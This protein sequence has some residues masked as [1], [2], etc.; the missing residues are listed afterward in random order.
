[1]SKIIHFIK[2]IAFAIAWLVQPGNLHGQCT[3]S[4]FPD[5]VTF[6][7]FSETKTVDLQLDYNCPIYI[8]SPPVLDATII[9]NT[10][11]ISI[12][13]HITMVELADY[14]NGAEIMLQDA[15][16]YELLGAVY[17]YFGMLPPPLIPGQ[18]AC[19]LTSIIAGTSPGTIFN[20]ESP[21]GGDGDYSFQWQL[22][23]DGGYQWTNILNAGS[24]F[25][26]CHVLNVTTIFRRIV[27]SGIQTDYSNHLVISVSQAP[28]AAGQIAGTV[29]S[30]EYGKSPGIFTNAVYPTGGTGTY[31]YQWQQS[32]DNG[33]SWNN[34]S[35]ANNFEYSCYAL[36]KPTLFRRSVFSGIQAAQSNQ[37][38]ISVTA[39]AAPVLSPLGENY[40][41]TKTMLDNTG[42]ASSDRTDYSDGLGR[43]A[44]TVLHKSS[45]GQKDIV[46]L[47]E[48]DE[49]GR[50][51]NS[52][53]PVPVTTA[54]GEFVTHSTVKT[55]SN[56]FYGDAYAYDKAVYEP[57]PLNR[58]TD[59]YGP[60]AAW[61]T[62]QKRISTSRY[63]NSST[64]ELSCILYA[65]ASGTSLQNKG[66]CGPGEL[67]VTKTTDEDGHI[68]YT[69][70]DKLGQVVLERVMNGSAMNDTYSVYDD[71]GN[72]R[73]VLPPAAAD[74]LNTVSTWTDENQTLKDYAYIYKYDGQSR[75][76]LKKLPGND[77]IE[78]RYDRADRPVFSQDGNRRAKGEWSFFF[79]DVFGRQTV[80][81]IWKSASLPALDNLVVKTGYTG[82]GTLAGHTVNLTLPQVEL[83][84]VNYYD[85]HAFTSGV[86]QLD[87]VTPP[88]GYGTQFSSAK[89]LLTGTRTYRLDDP[90]RYTASALYYDYR[91]RVV[92][93]R[94]SN[95]LGGFDDEYFGYT[96]TGKLMRH[97][98]VHSAPG[99]TTQ[100]EVYAYDYG[101]PATNPTERLLAVTHKLN[102]SA[103]VTLA[104]YT[105]EEVGRVQTKKLA[106]ETSTY[107]YNVRS[108]LTGIAGTRFNQTL[109]YNAAVNGIIPTK[110]LYNGNIG[111]MKWKAGDETTERGY[112]F[113]Y[114]GLNRLTAAA[115]GEGASLTSNLNRFNEAVTEYDKAGNIKALERQGKLDSGYGMMD[116]LTYTY[117]GNR[118]TRVSDVASPAITYANAFHFV[119][120]ANVAN[121]YTYDANGN[122]T[123]D[124]NRNITSIS[125]NS[126][127]LPGVINFADGNTITYGYDGAGSKL[128]V[129]YTAGGTTTKTEYAGNKVYKNGTLSMI[130]TEE[131]YITLSGTTPT[132]HYYLKDH[133][134]NNRVV[135][136]QSGTMEQVNHYYPFGGLFGEGLQASN[137]PYRYNGKELDR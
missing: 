74:A 89:G 45:P 112:K 64:G 8:V 92:Q 86:T 53:I 95:H 62:A 17:V 123:K 12:P 109:A 103:A 2:I 51:S 63:T 116:N 98:L 28:L 55:A 80:S 10:L 76:I 133:Q 75:C 22:S 115:Y 26:E 50:P 68:S 104:Q 71:F 31:T 11:Y 4:V 20:A 29:T 25:Y 48:Y 43:S 118:L 96:F 120:R 113:S 34:I 66:L 6:T 58:I 131:G 99:K 114:D 70:A 21:S 46:T 124:L 44:Q 81:G 111:A 79:Y 24:D 16:S 37:L 135:L 136:S 9:G 36:T 69:F 56:S 78:M 134:G 61:H 15:N 83:M 30:V 40:I 121:E 117:T 5:N 137:Q 59:E 105:Y 52:Y 35:G 127:N 65:I 91:E 57:S 27:T 39:P 110:A 128:S 73:Y 87:Y 82:T 18:I 32:T 100:T 54:T 102:G 101:T 88:A 1:M 119:D 33:V 129:A 132:Y 93:S 3:L 41:H 108:W 67:F 126:L 90:S 23:T 49:A 38:A 14:I 84:T 7:S 42:I 77:P 107:S 97:Q 122:L 13:G 106:T 72:L 130:L 85:D 47:Q 19:N 60:G 125:Y 94:T